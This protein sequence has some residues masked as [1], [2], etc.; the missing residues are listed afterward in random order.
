M[1]VSILARHLVSL[2]MTLQVGVIKLLKY[3][4]FTSSYGLKLKPGSSTSLSAYV[5]ANWAGEPGSGRRS[6]TGIIIYYGAA[7]IYYSTTLHKCVTLSSTE[8]EFVAMSE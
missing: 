1:V 2:K 7:V 3:L 4:K 6:R 5:D 8:A